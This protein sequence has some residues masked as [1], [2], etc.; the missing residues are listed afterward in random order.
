MDDDGPVAPARR[1]C[2]R[3]GT[4]GG[5]DWQVRRDEWRASDRRTGVAQEDGGDSDHARDVVISAGARPDK[6][7]GRGR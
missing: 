2:S 6:R 4:G 7:K 3:G 1:S 5:G